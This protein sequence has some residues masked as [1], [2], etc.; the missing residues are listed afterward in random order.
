MFPCL[1][2]LIDNMRF[3]F[4]NRLAGS[5]IG[6]G[7]NFMI[8][9]MVELKKRGHELNFMTARPLLRKG[10]KRDFGIPTTIFPMP[11][12]RYWGN[13]FPRIPLL[14]VFFVILDLWIFRFLVL[15][16]LCVHKRS[17]D[18]IIHNGDARLGIMTQKFL[19]IPSVVRMPGRASQFELSLLKRVKA[20][21]ANGDVYRRLEKE[22]LPHLYFISPGVDEKFF[23]VPDNRRLQQLRE[24]SKITDSIVA[25]FVGRLTEIKNIG[26][27][28]NV[29]KILSEKKLS[30]T[31]LIIGEGEQKNKLQKMVEQ[32]GIEDHVRFL[33]PVYGDELILS[34]ALADIFVLSSLYDNFPQVV[35]EAMAS[36]LPVVATDVGGVALQVV[37]GETGY[38]VPSGDTQAFADKLEQLIRD[39]KKRQFFG[40]NGKD[41]AKQFTWAKASED[42]EEMCKKVLDSQM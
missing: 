38:L 40:A 24:N 18:I 11:F 14:S 20:V 1:T 34:Y 26:L 7:E 13:L 19:G 23:I 30:I 17:Y 15:L 4:V 3:L 21:V 16:R 2:Y 6:G 5:L 33:G 27:L 39:E 9:T 8:H 32:F 28:I 42:F 29:W 12:I 36:G 25:L 37:D 10:T 31:L 22:K 35:N 41:R